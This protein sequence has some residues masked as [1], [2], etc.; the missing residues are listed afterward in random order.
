M[1]IIKSSNRIADAVATKEE[2]EKIVLCRLILQNSIV[3]WN[4][5]YLSDLITKVESQEELE[6]FVSSIRNGT[7]VA[8]EHINMLGEYDFTKLLKNKAL[9]FDMQNLMAM[10]YPKAA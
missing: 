6:Y 7:A 5:L 3:L 8:W 1:A 9:R 2:Q 10:K 4:Y